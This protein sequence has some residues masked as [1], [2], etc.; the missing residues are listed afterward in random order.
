[1][2]GKGFYEHSVPR[3]IVDID[4]TCPFFRFFKP[5]FG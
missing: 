5:F 3:G 1:L 4:V 2:K